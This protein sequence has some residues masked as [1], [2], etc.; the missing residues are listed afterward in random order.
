MWSGEVLHMVKEGF[1][2]ML[3]LFLSTAVQNFELEMRRPPYLVLTLE[4][5]S[6]EVLSPFLS[7]IAGTTIS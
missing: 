4:N 1:N 6:R 7:T 3:R 5:E 2:A